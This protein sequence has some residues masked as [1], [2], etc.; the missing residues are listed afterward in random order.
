MLRTPEEIALLANAIEPGIREPHRPEY[1]IEN[2]FA[3][4][5]SGVDFRGHRVLELGPGHY[6]FCEAI[7]RRNATAEVVEL[8]PSVVELG[9]RRGFK[10]HSG[11]LTRLPALGLAGGYDGLFCKGSNNP[12]WF[13]NDEEA[14]RAYI[15]HLVEL[16]KE[17]GWAWIVSCPY[18]KQKLSLA[19]K[20][21]WLEVEDR[22]YREHGFQGWEV[23][24]RLKAGFFGIT[25]IP[26]RLVVYTRG[27]PGYRGRLSA[28]PAFACYFSNLALGKL[29]RLLN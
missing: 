23:P 24:G 17:Q 18:S 3:H 28:L 19:E 20:L 5:M 6:E 21:A 15:A 2:I 1:G 10:A 14:L 8:D 7:R 29:R 4:F 13:H 25:Y 26:P 12:F 22:I 16:L 11:D 27:L 9:R